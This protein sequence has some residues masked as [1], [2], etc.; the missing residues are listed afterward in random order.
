MTPMRKAEPD[1]RWQRSHWHSPTRRGF[2]SYR[3]RTAPHRQPPVPPLGVDSVIV[4]VLRC[5]AFAEC[6]W[7]WRWLEK[8]VQ[9]AVLHHLASPQACTRSQ[10]LPYTRIGSGLHSHFAALPASASTKWWAVPGHRRQ[11]AEGGCWVSATS[12]RRDGAPVDDILTAG[13][14]CG[15]IGGEEG[16]QL[17]DLCRP[18][19]AA[20]RDAA[21]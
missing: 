21:Q 14:R 6:F 13:D 8:E 4:T 10:L 9:P 1:C 19:R 2:P 16:D 7:S 11:G 15:A 17:G 5:C 20:E 18:A 12:D 3:Y